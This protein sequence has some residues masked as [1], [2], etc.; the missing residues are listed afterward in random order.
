MCKSEFEILSAKVLYL[1]KN[2]CVFLQVIHFKENGVISEKGKIT[3]IL[4]M[5][6]QIIL[7]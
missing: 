1:K 7:K 3:H 4:G 5:F 6:L 2:G